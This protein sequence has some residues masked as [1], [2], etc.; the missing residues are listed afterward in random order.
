MRTD[1]GGLFE[2]GGFRLDATERRLVRD[3]H[4]VSLTPKAFH[5]LVLLVENCGHVLCKEQLIREVWPDSFVEEGGLARNISVLRKA[6]GDSPVGQRLIETVP[7][8]GYRFVGDVK[9]L[10]PENDPSAA[11]ALHEFVDRR[12][13]DH[14]PMSHIRRAGVLLLSGMML[15]LVTTLAVSRFSRDDA[16]PNGPRGRITAIGCGPAL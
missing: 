4:P 11:G 2:F 16:V 5:T 7:K 14:P 3:G 15:V 9:R 10:L 1:Q 8:R 12:R 6:L 13:D